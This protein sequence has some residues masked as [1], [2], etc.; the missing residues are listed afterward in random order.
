MGEYTSEFKYVTAQCPKNK[1]K[2][3]GISLYLMLKELSLYKLYFAPE[4]ITTM[5]QCRMRGGI[6]KDVCPADKFKMGKCELN[7]VCCFPI[8]S[9]LSLRFSFLYKE[10]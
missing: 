7:S 6:C 10:R 5:E 8:D 2:K 1:I 3:I 9:E 4:N